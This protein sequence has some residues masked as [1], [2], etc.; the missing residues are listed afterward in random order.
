MVEANAPQAV[1]LLFVVDQSFDIQTLINKMKTPITDDYDIVGSQE[2][3]D[4]LAD[5]YAYDGI[6]AFQGAFVSNVINDQALHS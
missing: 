2:A 1:K 6:A 3:Y 4:A 5:K